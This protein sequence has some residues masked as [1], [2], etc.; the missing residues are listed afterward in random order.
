MKKTVLIFIALCTFH[1]TISIAMSAIAH[2]SF[3]AEYHNGQGLWNFS[4][5]SFNYHR[6][7][8]D[9]YEMLSNGEYLKWWNT[10]FYRHTDYIGLM[11]F[12]IYP[13]PVSFAPINAVAWALSVISIYLISMFLCQK[14]QRLSGIVAIIFGLWPSN[15][16]HATQLLRDPFFNL[17][18]LLLILGWVAMLNGHRKIVYSFMAAGG[19]ILSETIRAES[20]WLLLFCSFLATGTIILWKR[21]AALNALLALGL[22]GLFYNYPAITAQAGETKSVSENSNDNFDEAE[23]I[24]AVKKQ[25][26]ASLGAEYSPELDKNI[27]TWFVSHHVW[28]FETRK[29]RL[30]VLAGEHKNG[31]NAFL[32]KWLKPWKTTSWLP[33]IIEHQLF[34]ANG[35]RNGFVVWYLEPGTS[36]IDS[37][38]IFRSI[39]DVVAYIPRAL[40]IGFC[41][42]FP[43]HWFS[44]GKTGGRAIRALGGMEMFAWYI[45]MAGF[46]IF[47]INSPVPVY[48]KTWLII[49]M[50]IM[51]LPLGLFVP[52]LGT[53]FRMRF[54][55]MAPILIGGGYGI[56]TLL[57][58]YIFKDTKPAHTYD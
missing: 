30:L 20:L 15:L 24:E 6:Q 8:L 49:F 28:D 17:G 21:Q 34:S 56:M 40:M 10:D 50:I 18:V 53:L 16:L 19:I 23:K 37:N 27:S 36:L 48:I 47:L 26:K 54:I 46:V 4:L 55:Y 5:D 25:L 11:Y 14:D 58:T 7:A 42:P 38:V 1:L 29:N 31:L 9:S 39:N 52:N 51:I 43:S 33:A 3:M 2:S 32:T 57:K 45:L 35:Y 12:L 22:V 44:T 13:S 41:A